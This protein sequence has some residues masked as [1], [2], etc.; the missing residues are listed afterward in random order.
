MKI[1]FII[2]RIFPYMKRTHLN[3]MKD[4]DGTWQMPVSKNLIKYFLNLK[5]T[6]KHLQ[7]PAHI[8]S[9][10]NQITNG[11]RELPANHI[12]FKHLY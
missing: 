8:V 5:Q 2:E 9:D 10:L 12:C 6:T 11:F 1:L 7:T 4:E 3:E